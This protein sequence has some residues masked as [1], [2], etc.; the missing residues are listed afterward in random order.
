MQN[1]QRSLVPA[2]F[3]LVTNVAI[4][5]VT[6]EELEE[7]GFLIEM[8]DEDVKTTYYAI[9]EAI[10]L[11]PGSPARPAEEQDALYMLRD[12]F[13]RMILEMS[14]NTEGKRGEGEA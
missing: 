7:D 5:D 13:F 4:S 11:W 2:R 6:M 9:T 14:F 10:R 3:H 1:T 8:T 12:N